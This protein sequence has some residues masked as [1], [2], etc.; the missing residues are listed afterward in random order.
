M[1]DR[2]AI[3]PLSDCTKTLFHGNSYTVR[4]PVPTQETHDE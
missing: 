3:S 1:T 2:Q 4:G